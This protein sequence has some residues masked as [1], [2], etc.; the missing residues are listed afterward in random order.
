MEME[1]NIW[2]KNS[3][4]LPQEADQKPFGWTL[5]TDDDNDGG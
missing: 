4:E 5:N 3:V 1:L 2:Q